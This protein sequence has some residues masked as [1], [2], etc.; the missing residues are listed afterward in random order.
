M[1]KFKIFYKKGKTRKVFTK[2]VEMELDFIE[3]AKITRFAGI[4][5]GSV[6]RI[7]VCK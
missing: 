6:G 5:T 4:S 7:E 2:I 3:K 1:K